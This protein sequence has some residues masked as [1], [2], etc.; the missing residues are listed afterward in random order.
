VIL[1][2][3]ASKTLAFIAYQGASGDPMVLAGV[4]L[5]M[6]VLGLLATLIPAFRA[7]GADPLLL[8][9]EE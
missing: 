5:V 1:G 8:L 3:F 9:R 6:T 2:I 4:V 7:L